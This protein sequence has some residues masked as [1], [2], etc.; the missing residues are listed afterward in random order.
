MGPAPT[1]SILLKRR[2]SWRT[3]AAISVVLVAAAGC[4]LKIWLGD[5]PQP[6]EAVGPVAASEKAPPTSSQVAAKSPETA[7]IAPAAAPVAK[8]VTPSEA[9]PASSR[10]DTSAD[11]AAAPARKFPLF[12]TPD[13]LDVRMPGDDM[14]WTANPVAS[15]PPAPQAVADLAPAPVA[16][17]APVAANRPLAD[18][19]PVDASKYTVTTIMATPRGARAVI[20]GRVVGVGQEVDQATVVAIES[21]EVELEIAGRH[22]KIGL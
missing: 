17:T 13:S 9:Q 7:P 8:T 19:G 6:V 2:R 20:N 10:S 16:R 18:S 5:L 15:V 14:S 21:H 12:T 1:A 11:M 22:V 4:G 3:W